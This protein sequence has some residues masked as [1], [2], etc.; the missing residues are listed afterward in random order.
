MQSFLGFFGTF[1]HTGLHAGKELLGLAFSDKFVW[2]T[3][4]ILQHKKNI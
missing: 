2:V 4:K 1:I 3:G